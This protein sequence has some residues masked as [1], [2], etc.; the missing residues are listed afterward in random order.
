MLDAVPE[1][2]TETSQIIRTRVL[3]PFHGC[4]MSFVANLLLRKP[5]S[6]QPPRLIDSLMYLQHL[7]TAATLQ[8]LNRRLYIEIL[9]GTGQTKGNITKTLPESSELLLS[10]LK[11]VEITRTP[12]QE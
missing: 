5:Q 10:H 1:K 3:C 12:T 8:H 9:F 4:Q 7:N 6:S 11:P 2:L